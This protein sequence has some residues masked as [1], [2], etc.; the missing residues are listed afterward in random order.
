MISL[1]AELAKAHHLLATMGEHMPVDDRPEHVRHRDA[2][3]RWSEQFPV[4]DD[5]LVTAAPGFPGLA[6]TTPASVAGRALLYFHGGGYT[7]GSAYNHR[8]VGAR[9]ATASRGTVYLPDYPLAPEHRFPAALDAAVAA[10]RAL[11]DTV[12][13]TRIAVGGDSAGGGLSLALLLKLKDLALPLPAAAVP[14]SPWTDLTVSAPSFAERAD[15]DPFVSREALRG[16]AAGYLGDHDPR[17]PFASPLFGDLTGLPPLHLEVGTEE[18]MID[19]SRRFHE[20]ALAAGVASELVETKGAPHIWQHFVSFLP[21]AAA[22]VDRIG[23]F[24]R[25][26]VA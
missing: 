7:E 2:Y 9:L 6:V 14:V 19:D 16:F 10:Y 24:V 20:R 11:L 18:V 12:P 5:A 8:E 3:R 21:E 15:R 25:E 22:S 23:A 13:A 26:H 1:S 17:D 4:P